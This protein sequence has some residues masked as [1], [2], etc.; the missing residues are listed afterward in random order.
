M[1]VGYNLPQVPMWG[2]CGGKR[3]ETL[4]DDLTSIRFKHTEGFKSG[5]VKKEK[6]HV[7]SL[8]EPQRPQWM[9]K[10]HHLLKVILHQEK[11]SGKIWT[12]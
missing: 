5:I 10:K 7:D 12:Q 1:K 4:L 6:Q 3:F 8:F 9:N 2:R 11:I